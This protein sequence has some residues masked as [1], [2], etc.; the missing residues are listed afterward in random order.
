MP[1]PT[2]CLMSASDIRD[3]WPGTPMVFCG[4]P[5]AG[6]ITF[7]CIHEHVNQAAAC[8]ACAA[9]IQ[10]AAPDLICPRCEDGPEPHECRC[11]VRITWDDGTVTIVQAVA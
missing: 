2:Y 9:E 4:E 5:P 8:A 7:A 11:D 3:N 6:T 1:A 10:R